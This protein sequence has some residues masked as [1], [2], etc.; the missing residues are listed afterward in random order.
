MDKFRTFIKTIKE[1][2][3][4]LWKCTMLLLYLFSKITETLSKILIKISEKFI[5]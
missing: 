3:I 1:I 5:Q 2:L 4:G